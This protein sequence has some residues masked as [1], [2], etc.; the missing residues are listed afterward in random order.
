MSMSILW[1]LL[2]G[3]GP[4]V[5]VGLEMGILERSQLDLWGAT[6]PHGRS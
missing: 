2:L 4:A 1:R 3:D 6:Q 5:V